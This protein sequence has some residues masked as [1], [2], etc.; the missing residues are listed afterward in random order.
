MENYTPLEA[1]PIYRHVYRFLLNAE[2][3]FRAVALLTYAIFV[4]RVIAV[5]A[6]LV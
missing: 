3:G 6:G 4:G 5:W 2:A 1:R